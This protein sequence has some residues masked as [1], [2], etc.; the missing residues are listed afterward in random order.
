MATRNQLAPGYRR[1]QVRRKRQYAS[2]TLRLKADAETWAPESERAVGIGR[3]LDASKVNRRTTFGHV[4]QLRVTDMR[5][6]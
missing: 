4:L 5:P 3:S 1:V 2:R 6:A